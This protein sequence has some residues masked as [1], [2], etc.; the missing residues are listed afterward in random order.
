[1]KLCSPFN[2]A[3]PSSIGDVPVLCELCRA[4]PEGI[5]GSTEQYDSQPNTG[6]R[7]PYYNGVGDEGHCRND[8]SDWSE[9]ISGHTIR[10]HGTGKAFAGNEKAAC[11][12]SIENPA[13]ETDV[14]QELLVGS[15]RRE[16]GGAHAGGTNRHSRCVEPWMDPRERKKEKPVFRH[17]VIDPRSV[18]NDGI[19]FAKHGYEN[20]N[21]YQ[22]ARAVT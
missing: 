22:F 13:E 3:V 7:R 14:S 6:L 21:R 12:K 19:G 20:G 15:A 1:M 18:E 2:D 17:S 8:E 10:A 5:S 9:R 16:H 11:G 4:P